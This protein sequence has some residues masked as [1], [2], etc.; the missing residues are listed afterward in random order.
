MAG[1][2]VADQVDPADQADQVD[3]VDRVADQVAGRRVAGRRVAPADRA[4]DR[5][6][7]P[8]TRCRPDPA[9]SVNTVATATAAF[10]DRR[11]KKARRVM[12]K[13]GRAA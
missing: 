9:T 10:S 7:S 6:S 8:K 13:R 3:Q 1:R 4:A 2:R 5:R 11:D 12:H